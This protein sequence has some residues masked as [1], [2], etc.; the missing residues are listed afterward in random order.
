VSPAAIKDALP[1]GD[2]AA[3]EKALRRAE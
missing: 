3:C 1:L 2:T